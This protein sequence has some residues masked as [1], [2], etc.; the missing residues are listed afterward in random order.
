MKKIIIKSAREMLSDRLLAILSIVGVLV[1]IFSAVFLAMSIRA[2]E[3]QVVVRYTGFGITNYYRDKWYYLL[4]FIAFIIVLLVIH[5][6]MVFKMYRIKGKNMARVMLT[7]F[8]ILVVISTTIFYN[9][10]K[11]ASL[12]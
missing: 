11:I 2:S 4:S 5:Y 7:L 1:S 12:T 3:L 10:L 9:L 8:I 6:M